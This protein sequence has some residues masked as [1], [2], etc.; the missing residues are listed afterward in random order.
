MCVIVCPPGVESASI[1]NV[2]TSAASLTSTAA[3]PATADSR[4]DRERELLARK[5]ELEERQRKVC[6]WRV[7]A[8][9]TCDIEHLLVGRTI[10]E[11]AG[12]G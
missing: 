12:K 9:C 3:T 1:N 10:E 7:L 5:K 2:S 4:A 11:A 8:L 6:C